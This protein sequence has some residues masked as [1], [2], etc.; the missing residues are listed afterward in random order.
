MRLISQIKISDFR[1]IQKG[2]FKVDDGYLPII[3]AN[4][5]GKS[6]ILRA[7]S[8]FFTN[9]IEP[10]LPLR[11]AFDFHNP[12]RRRKKEISISVSFDLPDYFNFH[13]KIKDNLDGLFDGRKFTI[14][15][16]WGY[17]NLESEAGQSINTF[18][19][20]EGKINRQVEAEDYHKIQQFLNLI[21]FRYQ[22]NHIHPSEVLEK[23]EPELRQALLYRL[24]RSKTAKS[25]EFDKIFGDIGVIASE[26]I[27]PVT[28]SLRRGGGQ[29]E[30]LELAT[31]KDFGE[32][33]FSFAPRLKVKGG[34]K[35]D[36][37]QHGS[38]V[39]SFLTYL[40]LSF[41]DRRFEQKFGWQQA[42]IWAIEEPESF[43]HQ[44]LQ[45]ELAALL[46]KLGSSDRF[47]VLCTT[48]SDVFSRYSQQGIL[49]RLKEGKSV[50]D[51]LS[52]R[53]LT[54]EAARRGISPYVHPLLYSGDRPLLLVEGETDRRFLKLA[55]N[56]LNRLNVWMICDLQSLDPESELQG[57][58]GL[59]SYLRANRG[60]IKT[61]PLDS[62]VFVLVD[63]NVNERNIA[64][65][66]REICQHSTSKVIK[67]QIQNSNP[68]L[69]RSFTGIEKFLSIN[70]IRE[71]EKS[72]MIRTLRPSRNE[73]PIIAVRDSMIKRK[74]VQLA[75]KRNTPDDFNY[76]K[77]LLDKLDSDLRDSIFKADRI[78]SGTLFDLKESVPLE[79]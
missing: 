44:T 12:A 43:L 14:T 11:L 60:A 32:L 45:H 4:N 33:L 1:S 29:I 72:G 77:S 22:P 20:T 15:K 19:Q 71:A 61:R 74:I 23:E 21:K 9:E 38:G 57:V 24:R 69:D 50:W 3:G 18:I 36:A 47:Q 52:S 67:W 59:V 56:V 17:S 35:F 10:S 58:D 31:P 64:Q 2:M 76:F 53:L 49:C 42:T 41:L 55:F 40:M 16:T 25:K 6:N 65:L 54:G 13:K 79:T 75:E 7:L 70:I 73:Y 48:H 62:P 27:A 66:N 34:E 28:E 37:L 30:D 5:S 63:W 39:Q 51:K 68:N 46:A 26:L 8:L 78:M